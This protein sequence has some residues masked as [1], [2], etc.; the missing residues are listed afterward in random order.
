M[1]ACSV[2]RLGR[3]LQDLVGLLNELQALNCNLYLHQQAID[4]TTP[5]SAGHIPAV[6]RLR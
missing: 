6:R 5:N 3:G 1:A 2:D 4:T